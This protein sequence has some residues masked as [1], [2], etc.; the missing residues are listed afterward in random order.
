MKTKIYPLLFVISMA[1]LS[2]SC[3]SKTTT[4]DEAK[5]HAEEHHS[6]DLVLTE[7]QVKAVNLKL[8]KTEYKNLSDVVHVNGTTALNPQDKADV[9]PLV[10]GS[11]RS[12]LVIEGSKVSRGQ[13]VAWIEN[14]EIVTLQREY[15]QSLATLSGASHELARQKQLRTDG[16]GVEKNLQQ[17]ERDFN[18]AQ[19]A[20]TGL[21]YQLRQ[22]GINENN[23]KRGNIVTRIPLKSPISGF[24][25]KIYKSTGSYANP[26]Q[27]VLT[28][29]DDSKM[30]IDINVYEKD[31]DRLKIGQ[32]VDFLLTNNDSLRLSGIIYEFASSFTDKTKSV[33]A[34]VRITD[35]GKAAKLIPGMYVTGTVQTGR[36]SVLAVPSAAITES[37]GK[38]YIFLLSHTENK[39]EGKVF[40]F[41]RAQV[42]AGEEELGFTHIKPFAN[43]PTNATI[44]TARAFYLSSMLGEEAEHVH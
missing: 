3:T 43:I 12:I 1:A 32:K 44:V 8:G 31:I 4:D 23:L 34:H 38:K 29:V 24:V 39:K 13:V 37:E 41:K 14:T 28:I 30:H 6:D 22:L 36:H 33:L 7:Q 5:E 2:F 11:L 40:H 9:S 42:T 35:K 21:A 16:A 10:G 25:D 17:A 15:L 18:M 27:P 26:E 19:A 20:V